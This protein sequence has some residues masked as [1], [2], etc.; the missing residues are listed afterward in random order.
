MTGGVSLQSSGLFAA[1]PAE[2]RATAAPLP[3]ICNQN[4]LKAQ[5]GV[6]PLCART[7]AE[8]PAGQGGLPCLS[9]SRADRFVC[10]QNTRVR[11]LGEQL[12]CRAEYES[13]ASLDYTKT[14]KQFLVAPEGKNNDDKKKKKKSHFADVQRL[15]ALDVCSSAEDSGS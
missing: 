13:S 9:H 4:A 12:G 1:A 15:E 5:F 6:S 3:T 11:H 7:A 2:L 8:P 10:M 14:N